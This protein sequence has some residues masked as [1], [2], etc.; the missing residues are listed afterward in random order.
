MFQGLHGSVSVF[1][2]IVSYVACICFSWFDKLEYMNHMQ[3]DVV[4]HQN[5]L[6]TIRMSLGTMFIKVISPNYAF[7]Y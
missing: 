4:I 5:T 3:M 6:A 2:L 7:K 1:Q